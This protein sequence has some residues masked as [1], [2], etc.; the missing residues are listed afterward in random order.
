[1][2]SEFLE[3]VRKINKDS[4]E[5]ARLKGLPLEMITIDKK[6][7]EARFAGSAITVMKSAELGSGSAK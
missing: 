6:E 1:M 7:Y 3:K 5:S 2:S 4:L